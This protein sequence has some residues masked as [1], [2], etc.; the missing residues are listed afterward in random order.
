M[1]SERYIVCLINE[2]IEASLPNNIF[3]GSE[4]NGLVIERASGAE[5]IEL[6]AQPLNKAEVKVF[7]ND[8]NPMMVYHRYVGSNYSESR[9]YGRDLKTTKQDAGMRMIVVLNMDKLK[10][11]TPENIE[12]YIISVMAVQLTQAQ[13]TDLNLRAC[14]IVANS[15]DINAGILVREF[16]EINRNSYPNIICFEITYQ[17]TT[18]Y[19]AGCAELCLN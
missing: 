1:A 4:Y 13:L 6:I 5:T 9:G 16:P 3:K 7:P 12:Q 15:S 17:I 14:N 8:S 11:T 19:G 10:N 18:L 2:A